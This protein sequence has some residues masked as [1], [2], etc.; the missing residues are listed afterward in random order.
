[1]PAQFLSCD[2]GTTSFRL[3]LVSTSTNEIIAD[4]TASTGVKQLFQRGL[5][6][7]DAR[8]LLFAEVM[9]QR[10]YELSLR[11]TFNG[12]PLII[13]GMASSTIGWK[14]LPYARIPVALDAEGLRVETLL[15]DSPDYLGPTFL[16]SGVATETNMMRGEECQAIG[17]LAE[18]N[19]QDF[20]ELC[21]LVLPGTHSKHIMIRYGRI[22]DFQ[23]YMTGELFETLS[24]HTILAAT[25]DTTEP[26]QANSIHFAAGVKQVRDKGLAASLFQTRTRGVLQNLPPE[27]NANFLSGV[28]IGAEMDELLRYG[29]CPVIVA[30]ADPLLKLYSLAKP[31]EQHVLFI[32]A[33]ERA[34][35]TAHRLILLNLTK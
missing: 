21:V 33:I 8:E 17:L 26:V 25:V 24:K 9:T 19:L 1:M 13:S 7:G 6:S 22:I 3:R 23:T 34:T 31:P 29:D 2:W 15:W 30:A 12:A 35:V 27:S 20:R 5:D 10:V 28:L 16:V 4:I 14:E 11:H 32:N 18:P